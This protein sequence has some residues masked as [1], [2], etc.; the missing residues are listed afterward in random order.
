MPFAPTTSVCTPPST[1]V[2]LRRLVPCCP[3]RH[4][5]P[6]PRTAPQEGAHRVALDAYV[7]RDDHHTPY[8]P[9]SVFHTVLDRIR[10]PSRAVFEPYAWLG[11]WEEYDR[12]MTECP[13]VYAEELWHARQQTAT[14]CGNARLRW[15]EP[16]NDPGNDTDT[17]QATDTAT[18]TCL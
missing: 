11:S 4:R 16:T 1:P 17:S 12:W 18:E 13:L 15:S 9:P 14:A 8:V 2:A 5:A 3:W 7:E 6:G 10:T